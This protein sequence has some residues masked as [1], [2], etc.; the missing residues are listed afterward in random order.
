MDDSDE[1]WIDSDSDPDNSSSKSDSDN[2]SSES[3]ND[4]NLPDVDKSVPKKGNH[5]VLKSIE[6]MNSPQKRKKTSLE[7]M[8]SPLKRKKTLSREECDF[9]IEYPNIFIKKFQKGNNER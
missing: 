9:D 4:E 1:S 5:Q 7:N 6:N 3:E 2:A 8:N